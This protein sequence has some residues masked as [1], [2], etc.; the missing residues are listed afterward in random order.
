MGKTRYPE[1]LYITENLEMLGKI[2]QNSF[3][4]YSWV[5]KSK[6]H[7]HMSKMKIK[8]NRSYNS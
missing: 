3:Q 4:M 7:S 1:T 8:H 5:Y 6:G 2:Q